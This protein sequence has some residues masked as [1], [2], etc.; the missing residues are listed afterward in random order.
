MKYYFYVLN[1][2]RL[3]ENKYLVEAID[4]ERELLGKISEKKNK[5]L[6]GLYLYGIS[7][8]HKLRSYDQKKVRRV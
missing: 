5:K 7:L 8:S 6:K 3:P 4:A 2:V 1:E